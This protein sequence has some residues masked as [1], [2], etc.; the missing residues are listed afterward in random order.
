MGLFN[1]SRSNFRNYE[2]VPSNGIEGKYKLLDPDLPIINQPDQNNEYQKIWEKSTQKNIQQQ[3]ALTEKDFYFY[4]N[5]MVELII[6]YLRAINFFGSGNFASD[7]NTKLKNDREIVAFLV[8]YY[9]KDI[10]EINKILD[11]KEQ[12]QK[13][14]QK[15]KAG[16]KFYYQKYYDLINSLEKED[17]FDK[18]YLK[19]SMN[20]LN[21]NLFL[22]GKNRNFGDRADYYFNLS[23]AQIYNLFIVPVIGFH[24]V[25]F[26]IAIP[27]IAG[28]A[29]TVPVIGILTGISAA[30][31]YVQQLVTSANNV[32]IRKNEFYKI[33][34]DFEVNQINNFKLEKLQSAFKDLK[35]ISSRTGQFNFYFSN[36]FK[37]YSKLKEKCDLVFSSLNNGVFS[38]ELFLDQKT[39]EKKRKEIIPLYFKTM[40]YLRS[41]QALLNTLKIQFDA[42]KISTLQSTNLL[43]SHHT[44]VNFFEKYNLNI[45]GNSISSNRKM[46]ETEIYKTITKNYK[47]ADSGAARDLTNLIY[48]SIFAKGKINKNDLHNYEIIPSHDEVPSQKSKSSD[49]FKSYYDEFSHPSDIVRRSANLLAVANVSKA[50]TSAYG[51]YTYAIN[52]GGW[53]AFS[54]VKGILYLS[55]SRTVPDKYQEITKWCARVTSSIYVGHHAL[56]AV[57]LIGKWSGLFSNSILSSLAF[58]PF[59]LL[60]DIAA[61]KLGSCVS[62]NEAG[63]W[64]DIAKEFAEYIT[65]DS[66]KTK[67]S[68]NLNGNNKCDPAYRYFKY[69]RPS[70]PIEATQKLGNLYKNRLNSIVNLASEINSDTIKL[71]KDIENLNKLF[72]KSNS[73]FSHKVTEKDII[74]GYT[75][76]FI[77]IISLAK[78]LEAYEFYLD[79]TVCVVNKEIEKALQLYFPIVNIENRGVFSLIKFATEP[80]VFNRIY[81][82]EE[83]TRL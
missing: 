55:N 20:N 38:Q 18:V 59:A 79:N 40:N 14:N 83:V 74:K 50:Y 62:N 58:S 69:K 56:G 21:N 35:K 64:Q 12:Y 29:S 31:N 46:I 71:V 60:A 36:S 42:L 43:C 34:D 67:N 4:Y 44:V 30:K 75:K 24:A 3:V 52:A 73:I 11:K 78:E 80:S 65:D 25:V 26:Y 70:D 82:G 61:I 1:S 57:D 81:N 76:T 68:K 47:K 19:K 27:P 48:I 22:E 66:D 37:Y 28:V 6:S 53:V 7:N 77:K 45:N 54:I 10:N 2:S 16:F 5:P 39:Y 72:G 9:H 32:L 49:T 23:D 15:L 63:I 41:N 8:S 33:K 17:L 13:N 51:Q